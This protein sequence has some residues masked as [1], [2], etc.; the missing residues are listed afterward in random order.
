MCVCVCQLLCSDVTYMVLG[1]DWDGEVAY[2]MEAFLT[3]GEMN[4]KIFLKNIYLGPHQKV[5]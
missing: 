5:I 4:G 2:L 3:L 1:F